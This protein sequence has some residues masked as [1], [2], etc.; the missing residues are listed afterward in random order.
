MDAALNQELET[1]LAR[2]KTDMDA[3]D[4][5]FHTGNRVVDTLLKMKQYEIGCWNTKLTIEAEGLLFP[6][7]LNIESY[8]L[9]IIL[10]NALDN[11]LEACCRL[12]QNRLE[13]KL[14]IRLSS[15]CKNN[16]FFLEI[17]N[18][19]DGIL[20]TGSSQEF[21][22][23]LKPDKTIHGIGLKNIKA[24]ALKYDGEAD[25]MADGSVFCLTVMMKAKP[26]V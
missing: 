12:A 21:P 3:F 22:L 24:T 17:S 15:F 18:S 16:L 19:F 25:W 4:T 23:T 13:A 10:G 2:L 5:D 6:D 14:F 11:A 8:D 9:A 7:G 26:N 20:N 1:Y